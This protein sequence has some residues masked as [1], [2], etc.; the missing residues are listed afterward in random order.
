MALFF[1]LLSNL[2]G[3]AELYSRLPENVVIHDLKDAPNQHQ[4]EIKKRLSDFHKLGYISVKD[5]TFED[6]DLAILKEKMKKSEENTDKAD[7]RWIADHKNLLKSGLRFFG[8]IYGGED[9]AARIFM[10]KDDKIYKL[11]ELNYR[12]YKTMNLIKELINGNVHGYP[13]VFHTERSEKGRYKA[14]VSWAD[15]QRHYTLETLVKSLKD[16][17]IGKLRKLANSL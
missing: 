2:V 1:L 10:D 16:P 11:S 9:I 15:N 14:L 4:Q 8:F 7:I 5:Y 12:K 6:H 3:A 17:R 13:A